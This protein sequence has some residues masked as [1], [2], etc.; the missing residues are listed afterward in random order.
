MSELQTT[1]P[2]HLKVKMRKM[3][4]IPVGIKAEVYKGA[5]C[6]EATVQF[7]SDVNTYNLFEA[8]LYVEDYEKSGHYAEGTAMKAMDAFVKTK[9]VS[10]L[11]KEAL[12]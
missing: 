8:L 10:K 6:L 5:K 11:L 1:T 4:S 3:K 12:S 2:N 7:N 9:A